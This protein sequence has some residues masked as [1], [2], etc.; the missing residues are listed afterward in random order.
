MSDKAC[1]LCLYVCMWYGSYFASNCGVEAT[2][3]G[4]LFLYQG[5]GAILGFIVCI[6]VF[7]VRKSSSSSRRKGGRG[8]E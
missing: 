4:V 3:L 8:G 5:M 1:E 2:A 6:Y 7:E